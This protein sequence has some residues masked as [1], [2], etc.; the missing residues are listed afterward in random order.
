MKTSN[1]RPAA[2]AAALLAAVVVLHAPADARAEEERIVAYHG[3]VTGFL[4]LPDDADA[5]PAIILMH[6]FGGLDD[7]MRKRARAYAAAGFVALALDA[8]DGKTFATAEA[9]KPLTGSQ[10]RKENHRTV[11]R[12]MRAGLS[13]LRAL[14]Q[15]D[16]RR[17]AVVGWGYGAAWSFH[18]AVAGFDIAASVVYYS[19][20]GAIT[21]PAAY[22]LDRLAAP[23]VAHY[24]EKS[25]S[26]DLADVNDLARRLKAR[27][28]NTEVHVYPGLDDRFDV[29]GGPAYDAAAAELAQ[30]RTIAFLK[31]HLA[32]G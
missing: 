27:N 3:D 2:V 8:F 11:F 14:S 21:A 30:R 5:A 10:V 4:A 29:E 13:H 15:I 17:V 24:P 7:E 23:I 32:G 31:R 1:S 6:D 22:K 25:S 28:R 18:M 19:S 20:S 26:S 16:P 9:A 12:N